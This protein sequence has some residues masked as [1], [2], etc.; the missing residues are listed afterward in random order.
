MKKSV[1]FLVTLIAVT[2]MTSVTFAQ[3]PGGDGGGRP[4]REGEGD[5]GRGFR[6]PPNPFMEALDTDKDG[7]ISADELKN[8]VESLTKL[9][10][11]SDGKLSEDEVRPPR[12]D[13]G[14]GFGGPP[15]GAGGQDMMARMM[16]MDTDK[17]GKISKEELPEFLRERLMER[18]DTNKDGFLD[19]EELE[20]MQAAG[21]AGREGRP[22]AE[23]GEG[24]TRPTR[25][26]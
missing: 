17:D 16:A 19:K 26:E 11:N 7:T 24:G 12:G 2:M 1:G 18:A 25:P 9:D 22:G 4:P 14:R 6:P 23:G 3:A 5:R 20:K 15:G 13:F 8:A 21:A 10:K